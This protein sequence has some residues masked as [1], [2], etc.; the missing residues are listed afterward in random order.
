MW[1]TCGLLRIGGG[2]FVLSLDSGVVNPVNVNMDWP[3]REEAV[4]ARMHSHEEG[5][6]P[7]PLAIA[8]PSTH[9]AAAGDGCAWKDAMTFTR[10]KSPAS[11]DQWFSGVQLDGLTD[12][13]LSLR[14]RDEF[15][16][17]WVEDYLDR[18][19]TRL[20]SSHMSI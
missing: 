3:P 1:T 10:D 5:S 13:V 15:V 19:S 11:F 20:N 17:Q 7:G 8:Q 2:G 9:H 16:R 12:G 6:A 14:A 18:K 4:Q